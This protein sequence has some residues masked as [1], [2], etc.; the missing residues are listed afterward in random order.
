M[1]LLNSF[2]P[3]GRRIQIPKFLHIFKTTIKFGGKTY[4][5]LPPKKV[6][7]IVTRELYNG[8]AEEHTALYKYVRAGYKIQ[9]AE[10]NLIRL[11]T[12]TATK[13]RRSGGTP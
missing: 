11:T 12:A 4:K 7:N 3:V 9:R 2:A 10:K 6:E 5:N 13:T 8:P 1:N